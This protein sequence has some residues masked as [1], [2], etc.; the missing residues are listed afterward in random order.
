ME[1]RQ[2]TEKESLA[3][4]TDMISRTK[5]RYI[6]DGN[7]MLMWGWLT[8]AVTGLVW[9]LVALT[10]NYMWNW[11]WFLIPAVGGP[12]T[13]F[14][15]RN[16]VRKRGVLTYSDRITSQIWNVVGLLAFLAMA[17]CA[18]FNF[19]G[20]NIWCLMFLYATVIVPFGEIAQ[21]IVVNEKILVVGGAIGMTIGMFSAACLVGYVTIYSYWFLPMFMLAFVCMMLVPGYVINYKYRRQ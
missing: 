16:A 12:T 4:I 2:F 11:L 1:N 3:L 5:S 14:M 6:G 17:I 13:Y 10:S 18:L 8:V 15:S 9:L 7:V 19:A 20:M 21:G